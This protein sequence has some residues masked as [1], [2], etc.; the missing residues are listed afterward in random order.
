MRAVTASQVTGDARGVIEAVPFGSAAL[1]A[2]A[3][4]RDGL[5]L[6]LPRARDAFICEA[7]TSRTS[8]CRTRAY[9]RCLYGVGEKSMRSCTQYTQPLEGSVA[10][11][12]VVVWTVGWWINVAVRLPLSC[13]VLAAVILFAVLFS[14]LYLRFFTA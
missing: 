7:R 10:C 9:A 12:R 2:R 4:E 11:F 5:R 8:T 13:R 3:R 14:S 6:F 1:S